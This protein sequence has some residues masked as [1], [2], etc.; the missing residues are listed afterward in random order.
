MFWKILLS[1]ILIFALPVDYSSLNT[2]NE[3][4][5]TNVVNT[6]GGGSG[7]GG[8]VYPRIEFPGRDVPT[9][10]LN[11]GA[12]NSLSASY[13]A[14]FDQT[15]PAIIKGVEVNDPSIVEIWDSQ[16]GIVLWG[17][18]HGETTVTVDVYHEFYDDIW[19]T[20]VI[21]VTVT[22]SVYIPK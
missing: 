20:T 22:Q 19:V 13:L 18:E 7:G 4:E 2:Q 11:K 5:V 3:K 14:G 15:A 21:P 1:S 6:S 17:R 8:Y 10:Y 9:I 16:Y 12:G